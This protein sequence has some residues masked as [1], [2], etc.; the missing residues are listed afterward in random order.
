MIPHTLEKDWLIFYAT[1]YPSSMEGGDYKWNL[2][3]STK[4]VPED[5]IG[6]YYSDRTIEWIAK[7][8]IKD[9]ADDKVRAVA[10]INY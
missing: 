3:Y 4:T 7:R 9:I 10:S 6:L 1:L 5:T 2:T 8:I